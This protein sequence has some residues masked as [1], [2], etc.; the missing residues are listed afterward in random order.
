MQQGDWTVW[1]HAIVMSATS[2]TEAFYVRGVLHTG[3]EPPEHFI[4]AKVLVHADEYAH[5]PSKQER[6]S[7]RLYRSIFYYGGP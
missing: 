5:G 6:S 1:R 7:R 2:T 4:S 3:S